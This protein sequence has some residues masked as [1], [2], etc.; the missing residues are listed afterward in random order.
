[1]NLAPTIE[2]EA[3]ATLGAALERAARDPSTGIRLLDRR[4]QATW[5]PW[6]AILAGA[7]DVAASLA[8]LGI[9]RGDRLGLIFPTGR[10]LLEAFF[11]AVLAGAVPTCLPPPPRFGKA[12]GYGRRAGAMLASVDARLL[13]A[14]RRARTRL[15]KSLEPLPLGTRALDDLPA[16]KTVAAAVGGRPDDLALI[17]FSSGTELSPKPAAL[18]HAA[19]LSQARLLNGYWPD[20]PE[21]RQRGV[22]WLPLYHDMG[23]IG[24]L[25]T[26]LERPGELTLLPPEVFA[27]RP[28]IWLRAISRFGGTVSPATNFAYGYCVERIRD[29]ELDGVDLTSWRVALNGA[30][31]VSADV[32]RRFARRFARWGFRSSAL[33]PVYGLAEA[34]LAVTFSDVEAPFVSRRFARDGLSPGNCVREEA[35]GRELVSVGRPV[36]GFEIAI[37]DAAGQGV[38]EGVVGRIWARGPTLMEGYVGRHAET[39]EVLRDGWLDTGDLG[40]LHRGELY[41]CGRIKDLIIVRGRNHSPVELERVAESVPGVGMGGAVA[42][43]HLP[44][45]GDRERLVL[46]VERARGTPNEVVDAI[47]ATCRRALLSDSGL[48]VDEVVVLAPDSIPRTSS[49]KVRRAETLRRWER[50]Q[51]G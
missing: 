4:E 32:M 27:A 35:G 23:L 46:F 42:V 45:G 5:L 40:F 16:G 11:G 43:G 14:E 34:A 6:S 15:D 13:L 7:R 28:A 20:T 48:E 22:S 1:M 38:E 10:E 29:R 30:E 17:Q 49:G 33:T 36:A 21:V 25:F 2:P 47:P 19:V 44:E 9:E 12:A 51:G 41:V 50:R 3:P 39:R 37:R 24:S 8:A 18:S 26:A 31:P